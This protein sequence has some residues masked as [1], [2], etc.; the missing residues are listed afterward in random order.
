MGYPDVS[1]QPADSSQPNQNPSE[2]TSPQTPPVTP[3]PA[4]S[5]PSA[6]WE[7]TYALFIHLTLLLVH[8]A[9]PVI[10][11]LVMWLIKR[12]Q[13]HFVDDHGKEAVNFQISLLIYALA[14]V[15]LIFACG[16]GIALSVAVWVLGIVGMIMAAVA[17]HKGQ[18]YRYPM[19]LRF[20]K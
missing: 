3:T 4:A 17:A 18:F 12:D 19:C 10:P 11:A 2:P 15:P 6:E 14:S 5:A 7:R 9:V 8:F 13:S 20:V 16:I 1:D